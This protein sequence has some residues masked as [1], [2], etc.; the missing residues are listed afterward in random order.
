MENLLNLSPAQIMLGFVLNIWI[1]V[2]FPIMV[3]KKLNYMSGLLEGLYSE[4]EEERTP[5]GD[6]TA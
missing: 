6:R 3:L 4:E 1:F 5:G 2:I